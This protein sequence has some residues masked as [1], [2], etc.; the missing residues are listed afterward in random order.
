MCFQ[1]IVRQSAWVVV[2]FVCSDLAIAQQAANGDGTKEG[3]TVRGLQEQLQMTQRQLAEA[4][5]KL[6]Q[7]SA[8]VEQLQHQVNEISARHAGSAV[9]EN[10]GVQ[11]ESRPAKITEDEWQLLN[12]QVQEQQ[13]TKVGSASK[14]R[15]K[16]SGMLL[17]N[18]FGNSGVVDEIDLPRVAYEQPPAASDGSFGASLRQSIFSLTGYGPDIGGA[19]TSADLQVDFFGGIPESYSG[20]SSGIARLRVARMRM[21]WEHTSISGGLDYLFFSPNSP[22][23]YATVAEPALASAG[24]LWTWTP[25]LRVEQ[26]VNL[27]NVLW[28]FEGGILDYSGYTGYYSDS[29]YATP[30]ESSKQPAYA[31]RISGNGYNEDHPVSFG[32]A[33]VITP[34]RY[35]G[36]NSVTGWGGLF[37]WK[38][39]LAP[40]FELSGEFF[41]GKGLG[42]FGG[43][44]L[45]RVQNNGYTYL[46]TT[47]PA[48]ARLRSVGGWSQLKYRVNER[49]E[50]NVAAGYGGFDSLGLRNAAAFDPNLE[51]I[52]AKNESLLVNYVL[53]PRSDLV[54][55]LE[56]RHLKTTQAADEPYSANH[57]GASAGF[58]F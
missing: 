24:N 6:Q 37:D 33:G 50:F 53:K 30:G 32:I 34:Q 18:V 58:I 46:A 45:P 12:A 10:S 38:T 41:A 39:P 27:A 15:L 54:F 47:A 22:T 5:D 2:F 36:G 7:L 11:Q 49:S 48:L 21:D 28:K 52:A 57:M 4:Q 29:R 35:P 31:V 25:T 20:Y 16:L 51:A 17:L 43:L 19:H 3:E 42:G 1:R 44:G 26:R 14:F 8:V 9:A 13:Q 56:Y 23:S 40:H 55:S